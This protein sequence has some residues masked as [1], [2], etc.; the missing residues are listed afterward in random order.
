MSETVQVRH[1]AM[2]HISSIQHN[3]I[4][5]IESMYFISFIAD[6]IAIYKTDTVISRQQLTAGQ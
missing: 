2:G 5:A 1:M 3:P 6:N 4:I